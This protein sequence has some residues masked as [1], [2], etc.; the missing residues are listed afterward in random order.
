M[1]FLLSLLCLH[2][3]A[4]GGAVG[5]TKE[6][7]NHAVAAFAPSRFGRHTGVLLVLGLFA[8]FVCSFC[9]SSTELLPD[10]AFCGD[11]SSFSEGNEGGLPESG[12]GANVSLK[13][14]FIG[15]KQC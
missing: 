2:S 8:S 9:E 13:C 7:E 4:R 12:G 14:S 5:E 15:Q 1:I 3:K 6:T 11:F 10:V